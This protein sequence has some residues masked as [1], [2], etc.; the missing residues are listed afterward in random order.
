MVGI[1]LKPFRLNTNISVLFTPFFIHHSLLDFQTLAGKS[2]QAKRDNQPIHYYFDVPNTSD[3]MKNLED[4]QFELGLPREEF[5]PMSYR[6][7]TVGNETVSTIISL[8]MFMLI[9]SMFIPFGKG[10]GGMNGMMSKA[11]GIEP[12]NIE[13]VKNTGVGH[14][15]WKE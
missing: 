6:T 10:K 3:F 7:A 15:E 14:S 13:I 12:K 2:Y 5:V 4:I 11:M 8:A 1:V 9:A